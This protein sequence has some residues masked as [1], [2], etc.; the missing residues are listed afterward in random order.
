M[1]NPI[2]IGRY[3]SRA[4]REPIHAPLTPRASNTSGPTQHIDAPIAESIPAIR[5]PFPFRAL[6]GFRSDIF[7]RPNLH[8]VPRY[9]VNYENFA[10]IRG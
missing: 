7:L 2:R 9:V 5:N 6:V 8:S 10:S 3:G 4:V 1:V